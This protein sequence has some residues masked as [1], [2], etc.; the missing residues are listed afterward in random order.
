MARA[1]AAAAKIT[2]PSARGARHLIRRNFNS[3]RSTTFRA[4]RAARRCAINDMKA[5]EIKGF[6]PAL[7]SRR[8]NGQHNFANMFTG[9]HTPMR[10]GGLFQRESA[11]DQRLDA[12]LAQQ[13]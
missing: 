8:L 11:V 9:L 6:P 5:R 13:R 10:V 12:P 7:G 2:K 1:G 3:P 4:K